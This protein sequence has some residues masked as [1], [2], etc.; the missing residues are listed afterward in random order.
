MKSPEP[1]V[2]PIGPYSRQRCVVTCRRTR[3]VLDFTIV[4]G[5][6]VLLMFNLAGGCTSKSKN[7]SG[8]YAGQG[9]GYDMTEQDGQPIDNDS[10]IADTLGI[11][12]FGDFEAGQQIYDRAL[13]LGLT[14]D[15]RFVQ[16]G[17][18]DIK[19]PRGRWSL[20]GVVGLDRRSPEL[21]ATI[22]VSVAVNDDVIW[23][24]RL[25][26]DLPKISLSVPLPERSALLHIAVIV[27][28]NP[29]RMYLCFGALRLVPRAD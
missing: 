17:W 1:A 9:S 21:N 27:R 8:T 10:Q 23:H 2:E 6:V 14:A 11:W 12:T 28:A 18:I 22:D 15:P 7:S 5:L 20:E 13:R 19:I 29:G 4:R 3:A 24:S 25:G 26:P 16:D